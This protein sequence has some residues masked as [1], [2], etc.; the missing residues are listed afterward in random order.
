LAAAALSGLNH[1]AARRSVGIPGQRRSGSA[2]DDARKGVVE[3]LGLVVVHRHH[4]AASALEPNAHDDE[5]TLLYSL[6]RSVTGP[7]L[8]GC[9]E[10]SPFDGCSPPLSR[11]RLTPANRAPTAATSRPEDGSSRGTPTRTD[12]PRRAAP[13]HRAARAS[14]APRT[15][16]APGRA[17][18]ADAT[19]STAR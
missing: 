3:F 10:L 5:A 14:A 19:C 17:A 6:H 16:R 13:D 1:S 2:R 18:A 9:H 4:E 8:H 15:R 7:R 11:T 12:R